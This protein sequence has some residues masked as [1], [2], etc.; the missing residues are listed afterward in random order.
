MTEQCADLDEF[1]D[2]ELPAGQAD[3]FRGHLPTCERCQRVLHGRM[4]EDIAVRMPAERLGRT[5]VPRTERVVVPAVVSAVAAP[6]P[7]P[8]PIP[9]PRPRAGTLRR[10]VAYAAAPILAAAAAIP[11]Y[12]AH[13]SDPEFGLAL[14]VKS[15]PTTERNRSTGSRRSIAAHTGDVVQPSVHGER[16]RAIRVYLDEHRLVAACPE[17]AGCHDAS[18]ELTLELRLDVPGKYVIVGLG[19][20]DPLAVPGATYEQTL[21]A[22]RRAGI[23]TQIQRLDVE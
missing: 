12:L 5:A 14:A 10:A 20:S 2:G 19:S 6:A 15:A 1:F 3:A 16:Y 8:T 23:H 11:I 7:A 4:Q 9:R 13:T 21:I 18:G 17:D 22:A